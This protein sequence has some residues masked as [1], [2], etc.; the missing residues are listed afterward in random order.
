MLEEKKREEENCNLEEMTS[1]CQVRYMHVYKS[2]EIL[3]WGK[4][5]KTEKINEKK[6]LSI[7]LK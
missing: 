3:L 5:K 1:D 7:A 6:E 2:A 4:K